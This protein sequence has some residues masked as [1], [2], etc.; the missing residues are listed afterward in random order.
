MQAYY[1]ERLTFLLT[2]ALSAVIILT[3]CSN[4]KAPSSTNPLTK[5]N[6][7][8]GTIVSISLY[9]HQSDELLTK[10]FQKLTELE[11][12]LSI[13]KTN[14]LIDEINSNAGIQP[15]KV[16]KATY[17]L[18]EKG[19][20]YSKL[21]SGA[22]DITVGPIVKLWNIG[23]PGAKVPSQEEIEAKLPLVDYNLVSLDEAAQTVYLEKEGMLLDLGG[24]GK[25]YA[26]DEV[27]NLLRDAG[28]EHAIIN[29]GGNV[30]G[31][32]NKPGD[33]LWTIGVQDPFNPRGDTI[34]TL[35]IANKSVVTSGIYER[36][37]E[38]DDGTKYHHILN[39]STGYPYMNELAGVT[40]I[41]DSST[42][43][44]ALST[45]TFALGVEDGLNF[46]EE[47]DGIDAVFITTDKNVYITSGIKDIFTLTNPSFTLC[48]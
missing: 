46:I 5:Q 16:D 19:L 42:D 44:D 47:L 20:Y 11:N 12:T 26:A 33:K 48:N 24:I 9:D 43:G 37:I 27:A 25:G 31:L 41:S 38:A 23:F 36:Y 6:F 34:G 17:D 45:S 30:Y 39:P 28:V 15:V 14:T 2:L 35:N 7:V 13:N 4:Q 29:L 22:F 1:K 8:L 40:I 21:T 3:G 10:A 18:I 32:G